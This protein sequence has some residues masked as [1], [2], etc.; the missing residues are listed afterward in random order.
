MRMSA[1]LLKRWATCPLQVKFMDTERRPEQ[2]NSKTA[3]GSIVHDSLEWYNKTGDYPAALKRF[4]THWQ[5]PALLN[6]EI[7]V[8]AKM[9]TYGSLL[10]KG[11]EILE[12]YNASKAWDKRVIVAAEHKYVVPMGDHHISGIIDLLEVKKSSKGVRSLAI[13]DYKT[14]A[15]QPTIMDLRLNVQFTFYVYATL[16]KEFWVGWPGYSEPIADNAEELWNEFKDMPRAAFW[17]HLWTSKELFAGDRD[18]ADFQ[19]MYRAINEIANAIDK[20]VYVPNISGTTCPFCP[21]IDVCG[22]ALPVRD[23]ITVGWDQPP[24]LF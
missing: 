20:D 4:E 15:R 13:V 6:C 22:V 11:R 18:D 5:N 8:W 21:Y 23:K 2:I 19:R 17:Y 14:S 9:T 24:L 1:S 3:F 7:D 12:K 16:Q 10:Q